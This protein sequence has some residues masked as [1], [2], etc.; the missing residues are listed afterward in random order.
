MDELAKEYKILFNGITETI[1]SLEGIVG[2]LRLLQAAAENSYL[3]NCPEA[4]AAQEEPK[5]IKLHLSG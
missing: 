2:R 5:L 4:K 1:E 3:E